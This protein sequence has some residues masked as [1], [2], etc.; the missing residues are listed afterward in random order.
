[1]LQL[2]QDTNLSREQNSYIDTAVLSCKRLA[3]LLGI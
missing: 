1:M 2:I 3:R